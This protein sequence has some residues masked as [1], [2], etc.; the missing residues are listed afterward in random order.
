MLEIRENSVGWKKLW[1]LRPFSYLLKGSDR[2][3]FGF[4]WPPHKSILFNFVFFNK[5]G[6][7]ARG[8]IMEMV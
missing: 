7:I 2:G 4:T 8:A 6:A 5:I 1:V 3:T